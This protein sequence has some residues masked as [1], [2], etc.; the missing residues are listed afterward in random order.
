MPVFGRPP[1]VSVSKTQA[2]LFLKAHNRYINYI[3]L[4]LSS[5]TNKTS[6]EG[7]QYWVRKIFPGTFRWR[8]P[9]PHFFRKCK[10]W[11]KGKNI[12]PLDCFFSQI[13][14][15]LKN[16]YIYFKFI[17]LKMKKRDFPPFWGSLLIFLQLSE[18]K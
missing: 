2:L 1:K 9:W 10:I 13:I 5:S 18:Q 7:S 14:I 16:I 4:K 17:V 3:F 6:E 12:E 11:L 15:N 8:W